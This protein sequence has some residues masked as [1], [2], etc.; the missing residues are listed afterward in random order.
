[1]NTARR[2]N[3]VNIK[4]A[5]EDSEVSDSYVE[6]M[7]TVPLTVQTTNTYTKS[8]DEPKPA[9]VDPVKDAVLS[10]V[11]ED[12]SEDSE[13]ESDNSGESYRSEGQTLIR[14]PSVEGIVRGFERTVEDDEHM[15]YINDRRGSFSSMTRSMSRHLLMEDENAN[16]SRYISGVIKFIKQSF[17]GIKRVTLFVYLGFILLTFRAGE[18]KPPSMNKDEATPNGLYRSTWGDTVTYYGVST[19]TASS[20]S[21][22]RHA[23]APITPSF[24]TTQYIPNTQDAAQITLPAVFNNLQDV[25]YPVT[26]TDI[27]LFWH[28]PRSAGSTVK[29]MLSSC[30]DMVLASE[31]GGHLGKT[32]EKVSSIN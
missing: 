16:K 30:F 11:D 4:P 2:R 23:M 13:Y 14:I 7:K 28:I 10:E 31:V 26:E 3:N 5:T 27:P 17:T 24:S 8:T 29:E 6:S 15:E 18:L 9:F 25:S 21:T 19:A 22:S 12:D 1:M 20:G 32:N